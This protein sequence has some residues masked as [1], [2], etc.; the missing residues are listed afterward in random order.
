ITTFKLLC[1]MLAPQSGQVRAL[2]LDPIKQ[3]IPLM[4]H[5]GVLF[6]NRSELWWDH[7]V[8]NS[9]LWKKAV[10]DIP[11]KTY[12]RMLAMVCDLLGLDE[13]MDRFARELS[14]GQRMRANLGLM[15]LHEPTLILLDEPTLGLDVLAKRQM[16]DFL[17][18][19]NREEGTTLLVTSHDMD[20]LT[21]M[22]RRILLI[23]RG[24][25]A[26]D[27][28]Y[29]QLMDL[30]GDKRIVRVAVPGEAPTLP[31]ATLTGCDQGKYS[32]VFDAAETPIA[33]LMRGM[34]ELPDVRDVETGRVPIETVIADLYRRWTA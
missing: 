5:T 27:G 29:D 31:G 8:R 2:G 6:G 15:L 4:A 19:I 18:H 14:L 21:E 33:A 13:L 9:F 11:D 34:A 32:Y 26:F 7:P 1:G 3:R 23:H 22:A 25:I 10:W 16:I 12:D 20:D 30:S 17:K 24:K 28:D